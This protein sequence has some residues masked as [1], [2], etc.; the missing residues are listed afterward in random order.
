[1]RT[2]ILTLLYR[3]MHYSNTAAYTVTC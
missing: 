2:V 1:M 3:M